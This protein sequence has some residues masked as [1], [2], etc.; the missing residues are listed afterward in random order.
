MRSLQIR[1]PAKEQFFQWFCH[2]SY[3]FLGISF[4]NLYREPSHYFICLAVCG[5]V[6]LVVGYFR[7]EKKSLTIPITGFISAGTFFMFIESTYA[8]IYFFGSL[9]AV[10]S[11]YIFRYNGRHV[12]NPGNFAVLFVVIMFPQ[13]AVSVPGQWGG[14]L[15]LI[16]IVAVL[17]AIVSIWAKRIMVSVAYLVGFILLST[18]R[19]FVFDISPVFLFGSVIGVPSMIYLF[20][21]ITDPA[22]SPEKI[23]NQIAFGL[24]IAFIDVILR[25]LEV[26][27]ASVIALILVTAFRPLMSGLFSKDHETRLS[28]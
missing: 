4:L 10:L 25:H 16:G 17:G 5:A 20:H 13:Y 14:E 21:M 12:F 26:L 19:G 22:T 27:Y 28:S 9:A 11:K 7:S 1:V 8:E 2:M 18:V 3:I 6:E 15:W 23:K 24:I